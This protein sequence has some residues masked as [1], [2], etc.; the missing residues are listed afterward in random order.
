MN[1]PSYLDL[2]HSWLMVA[3]TIMAITT[4]MMAKANDGDDSDGNGDGGW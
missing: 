3:M 1:Y 4:V 2:F